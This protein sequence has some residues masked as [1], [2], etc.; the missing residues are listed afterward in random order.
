MKIHFRSYIYHFITIS[1]TSHALP[2]TFFEFQDF[3]KADTFNRLIR[4]LIQFASDKN[5]PHRNSVIQ[6][7]Q[8][9]MKKLFH[10]M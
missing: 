7:T 5:F 3:Q 9:V 8:D 2:K 6:P 1:T 4:D 10:V